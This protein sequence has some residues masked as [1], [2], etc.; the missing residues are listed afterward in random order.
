LAEWKEAGDVIKKFSLVGYSLGI[1]R[2]ILQVLMAGGLIS[3]Y[4]IGLLYARGAFEKMQPINFTTFATP[5]L[6]IRHI[7][8]GVLRNLANL[9]GPRLLSSS[10]RQMFIADHISRPLLLRMSEKGNI[11]GPNV[12]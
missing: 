6:G 9:L 7:N 12:N 5:H 2:F 10:G 4:V 8:S 11:T 3:R 1:S